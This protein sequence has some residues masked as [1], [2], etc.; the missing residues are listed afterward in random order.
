MSRTFRDN[1]SKVG[2]IIVVNDTVSCNHNNNFKGKRM[3]PYIKFHLGMYNGVN[4]FRP[5]DITWYSNEGR[6]RNR[7][8]RGAELKRNNLNRGMKKSFRQELKKD[9]KNQLQEIWQS[10]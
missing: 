3:K 8:G 4:K 1:I 7:T 5:F 6:G 2:N 9:L 10:K